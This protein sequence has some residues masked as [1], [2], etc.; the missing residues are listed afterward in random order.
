MTMRG[1]VKRPKASVS[2]VYI[3]PDGTKVDLG[4][5]AGEGRDAP[6]NIAKGQAARKRIDKLTEKQKEV[7][8]G[9]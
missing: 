1:F 6:D 4:I 8:H 5:L 2:A 3:A 7:S 9:G